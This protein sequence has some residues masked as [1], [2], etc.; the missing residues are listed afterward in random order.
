[1][2]KYWT[3]LQP[4]HQPM[5]GGG[6]LFSNTTQDADLKTTQQIWKI[7]L[8]SKPEV[9]LHHLNTPVGGLHR[10]PAANS[11]FWVLWPVGN[12]RQLSVQKR[13]SRNSELVRQ[14]LQSRQGFVF[15]LIWCQLFWRY[16]WIYGV[17]FI[18]YLLTSPRIRKA[19]YRFLSDMICHGGGRVKQSKSSDK[20]ETFWAASMDKGNGIH[21][22]TSNHAL[23]TSNVLA[24]A[25]SC[26]WRAAEC[27][28]RG[29]LRSWSYS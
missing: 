21:E 17:N 12:N 10:I 15:Y 2:F 5:C 13:Q 24:E 1:M 28:W 19:Y 7:R 8:W 14:S 16:W 4:C 9:N 29:R 3:I 26:C 22:L 11:S 20:L 23:G 25:G 27:C 18:I 6:F